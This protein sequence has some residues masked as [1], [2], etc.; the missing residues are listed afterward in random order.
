MTPSS[1]HERIQ[2]ISRQ[3]GG[4]TRYLEVGVAKGST[5]FQIDAREKHGVDPRF[6][7]DPASRSTYSNEI[8]HQMTSDQYFRNVIGKEAPFDLIF[9]DGLHTY[10]Q[11]LRDFLSTLALS[12]S[13]TVWLIDDTVPTDPVAADPDLRKV[14]AAR[15]QEGKPNDETWMGDVFKVVAFI[16][17]F[18]PQFTCL[19]LEGHGQ[20]IVLPT[21]RPET[22]IQLESTESIERLNYVDVL[23]LR[24]S[25]L[26]PN[27]FDEVLEKVKKVAVAER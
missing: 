13:K 16:D 5:F 8:Y 21:P 4:I 1:S 22:K 24:R 25:L 6:R 12:H 2:A 19:T 7:F 11:T 15:A 3:L 26:T 23:L 18:C 10:S 14:K 17:T 27:S 20:T 9:L